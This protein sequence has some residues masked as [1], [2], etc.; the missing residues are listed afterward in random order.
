MYDDD[1]REAEAIA[2]LKKKEAFKAVID[3]IGTIMAI[4]MIALVTWLF[5]VITPPQSSAIND[6]TPEVVD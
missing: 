6:L 3:C 4:I 2:A 5:I 1:E